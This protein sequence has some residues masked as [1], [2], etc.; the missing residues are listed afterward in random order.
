MSLWIIISLW[1]H[2]VKVLRSIY[3]YLILAHA[4]IYALN[5]KWK[6]MGLNQLLPSEILGHQ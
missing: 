1:D 2:A 3:W 4:L 5:T 6:F